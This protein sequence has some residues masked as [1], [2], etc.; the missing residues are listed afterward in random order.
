MP[1]ITPE[2]LFDLESNMQTITCR[3]FERL[4]SNLWWRKICKEKP[5][6][7]KKERLSWLLDSAR[8]QRTTKTG[9]NIEFEDIVALSTEATNLNAAAG[10]ELK[11]EQLEDLDGNGVDLAAHWSRQMGAYAAYWPQK[12]LSQSLLDNPVGYDTKDF[13]A[14]DHPVN[15][16]DLNAG[17]YANLFTGAADGIYPGAV[18]IDTSVSAEVA[19]NNIAKVIAYA[20]SI[21]MPNGEDPRFLKLAGIMHAPLLTARVQQLTGAKFLAQ[22]AATGAG[23]ADVEAIIRNMGLGVPVEAPELGSAFGGSDTDYYLIMEE[24]T[25]SELGAFM[26][27]NR[28]AFSILYHGPQTDAQLARIRKFQWT[29]EGRN[30]IMPGHPYLL[31]K[32]SAI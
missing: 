10:L 20:A 16:F 8:I 18:P 30:V 3:E 25:S 29:T 32:C 24:I 7:S 27:V 21:K 4:L 14:D 6:G 13:F 26:Y 17:T 5:S 23:S 9:G 22:V 31:F 1:A 12:M 15:P 28:E 19:L 2:F 11:K